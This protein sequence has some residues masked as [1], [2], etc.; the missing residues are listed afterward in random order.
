MIDT[1]TVTPDPE[2]AAV[3]AG[4]EA[5][6]SRE[7]DLPIGTTAVE[8]DSRT[9]TVRTREA[10]IGALIADAMRESTDAEA[11]VTNGGGIRGGRDLRARDRHHPPRRPGR[12]AVRQSRRRDRHHRHRAPAGDRE[13]SV[14]AAQSGR[15]VSAGLGPDHR[16]RPQP[17]GRQPRAVDEGRR[18]AARREPHVPRRHQRLHAARR[19][20]LQHVP[21]RHAGAARRPT[22]R[23]CRP[24]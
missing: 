19:R 1:A 10:A 17:A 4:Y 11:A 2:I 24:T 12:T 13:R 20:R 22:H 5:Q 3:V 23:C 14:A 7:L 16:G 21:R 15:P 9:R 8:L 6:L 18:Q